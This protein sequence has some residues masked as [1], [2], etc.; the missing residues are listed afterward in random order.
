[1]PAWTEACV[2][3]MHE[4]SRPC[5]LGK[6]VYLQLQPHNSRGSVQMLLPLSF[7][8]QKPAQYLPSR[9][10]AGNR[11]VPASKDTVSLYSSLG[12]KRQP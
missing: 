10:G 3:S 1:M 5:A 4:L 12:L 8:E 7:A 9:V 11:S 2:I 6:R